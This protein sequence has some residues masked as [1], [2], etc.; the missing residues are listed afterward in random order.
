MSPRSCEKFRF[1]GVSNL[2]KLG[3]F[4]HNTKLFNHKHVKN[5]FGL[6]LYKM[7]EIE[8][9]I[10]V[11]QSFLKNSV[12]FGANLR[13]GWG[14]EGWGL[15]SPALADGPKSPAPPPTAPGYNH[16]GIPIRKLRIAT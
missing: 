7:L 12:Q 9:S 4:S 11:F 15:S 14:G 10:R 2:T 16:R 5:R 3:Y 13:G 8:R 6:Y 1:I